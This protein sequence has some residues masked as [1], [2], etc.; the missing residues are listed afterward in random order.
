MPRSNLYKKIER[1][2]LTR[3]A[4]VTEPAEG[5]G[6]R[7]GRHRQGHRQAG[8]RAGPASPAPAGARAVVRAGAGAG[9]TPLGGA[10]LVLG[11]ARGRAGRGAPVWP[12][13]RACG[14]QLIFY[15]GAAGVTAVIAMLGRARELVAPARV[16]ARRCRCS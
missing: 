4:H 8:Q 9:A 10:H 5:L 13:Q 7:D 1:Y 15:L 11:R 14:L 3:E 12:Y 6:S 2:G 16:R